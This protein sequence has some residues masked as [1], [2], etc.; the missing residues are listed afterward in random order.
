MDNSFL[1]NLGSAA[2]QSPI[3]GYILL[4]V[5]ILVFIS[6]KTFARRC[7]E[8]QNKTWGTHYNE[9]DIK[10][11]ERAVILIVLIASILGVMM[12]L[13]ITFDEN[14]SKRTQGLIGGGF[15]V[16]VGLALIFAKDR[17]RHGIMHFNG[18]P[19]AL[20]IGTKRIYLHRVLIVLLGLLVVTTGLLLIQ[21]YLG[22]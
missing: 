12:A 5:A 14:V 11:T 3:H 17:R 4:T 8:Y 22:F 13:G 2:T 1:T 19:A 16:L 15:F 10:V 21:G 6:R 20:R 18:K 9:K 7:I